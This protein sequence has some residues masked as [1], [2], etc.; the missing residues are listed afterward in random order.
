MCSSGCTGSATGGSDRAWQSR[1]SQRLALLLAHIDDP[2]LRALSGL[3][4]GWASLAAGDLDDA[5][6]QESVS[7]EKLR[8]QDEPYW[9]ATAALSVGSMQAAIGRDNDAV[10]HLSQAAN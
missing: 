5:I 3:A 2:Y 9:T 1:A 4:M 7:L 6:R 8:G 10:R